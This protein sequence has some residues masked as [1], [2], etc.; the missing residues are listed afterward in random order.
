[1]MAPR[2]RETRAERAEAC[3]IT[4]PPFTFIHSIQWQIGDAYAPTLAVAGNIFAVV[5][6]KPTR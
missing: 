5:S 2:R 3:E 1:M 4:P 6:P